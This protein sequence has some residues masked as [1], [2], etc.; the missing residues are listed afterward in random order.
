MA[1]GLW[2]GWAEGETVLGLMSQRPQLSRGALQSCPDLG[3]GVRASAVHMDRSWGAGRPGRQGSSFQP[4]PDPWGEP[5]GH[6]VPGPKGDQG[7]NGSPRKRYPEM[8]PVRRPSTAPSLPAARCSQVRRLLRLLISPGRPDPSSGWRGVG[9]VVWGR[10][11]PSG[12]QTGGAP[13]ALVVCAARPRRL[14]K[15]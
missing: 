14:A 13:R 6:A 4:G 5:V 11:R 8:G 7:C 9:W 10:A 2:R 3:P 1:W 12:G 15:R